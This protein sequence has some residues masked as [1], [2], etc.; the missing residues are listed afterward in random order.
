MNNIECLKDKKL[1]IFDVDGTIALSGVAFGFAQR[2]F[3][4]LKSQGKKTCI[5]TNNSSKTPAQYLESLKS[6]GLS[7]DV[8]IITSLDI[9]LDY[10]MKNNISNM[11]WAA[12][13]NVS[14]YIS[15]RGFT[16]EKE[17]P[18]CILLTYDTE[19]NYAKLLDITRLLH[20][21]IPFYVTH[22]DMVC[23]TNLGYP[24]PDVGSFMALIKASTGKDPDKSFGKPNPEGILE[25][26][27]H[28]G[29]TPDE[30]VMFGDRLYTDILF[31]NNACISS[32]LVLSGETTRKMYE[33]SDIQ[34]DFAME[35]IEGLIEL[36]R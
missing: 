31:A 19:L 20:R 7:E 35:S 33:K 28:M 12:N 34:A 14:R 36:F 10:L 23:P 15:S 32:V 29:F 8:S 21:S 5:M 25:A 4:A 30:A 26:I 3:C 11:Y 17:N 9:S 18:Q 27:K 1:F 13:T 22:T 2:V 6:F 24:V 16:F